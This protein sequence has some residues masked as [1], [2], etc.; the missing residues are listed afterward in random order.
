LADTI[1]IAEVRAALDCDRKP[2]LYMIDEGVLTAYQVRLLAAESPWRIYRRSLERY[3]ESL[4]ASV[5]SSSRCHSERSE[6]SPHH[7]P[8][9]SLVAASRNR[10]H[11]AK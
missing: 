10:P 7:A 8:A 4:R 6:E 2:V 5:G 11:S 1:T 9:R 3:M